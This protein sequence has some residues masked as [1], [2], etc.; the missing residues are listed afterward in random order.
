MNLSHALGESTENWLAFT[1]DNV[2]EEVSSN[3][4]RKL[5]ELLL[6]ISR[7]LNNMEEMLNTSVLST[8]EAAVQQALYEVTAPNASGKEKPL[9]ISDI[10]EYM[11]PGISS[12]FFWHYSGTASPNY[13]VLHRFGPVSF[14]NYQLDSCSLLQAGVL[15]QTIFTHVVFSFNPLDSVCGAAKTSC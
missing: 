3:L 6:A 1:Q 10:A 15:A 11:W 12:L 4:D 13:F 5:F 8:E 7:C 9:W 2:A 14:N